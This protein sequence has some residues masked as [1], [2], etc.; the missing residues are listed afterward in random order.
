VGVTR[1]LG[2]PAAVV[3]NRADLGDKRV[4]AFCLAEEIPVVPE[5]PYD[6]RLAL[7]S[8]RGEIFALEDAGFAGLMH[9]LMKSV[10]LILENRSAAGGRAA[11]ALAP[12]APAALAAASPASAAAAAS[13]GPE[14]GRGSDQPIQL[15]VLSGK[16]GAGK[17]TITAAFASLA[18][19]VVL[20]DCDVDAANLYLVLD[21]VEVERGTFVSGRTAYID[22]QHCSGC[23]ACAEKCRFGAI[24]PVPSSVAPTQSPP[25]L[26]RVDPLVCEGCALCSYA[27]TCRAVE[28]QE[29]ERGEWFVSETRCGPLVH[30]RL[31]IGG[32]NSGKLVTQVREKALSLAEARNAS[33]LLID[34]PP[35]IGCPAIASVAGADFVLLVTEPTVSGSHDLFRAVDLVEGFRI[36]LAVCVNKCD[37]NPELTTE[38]ER[39]CLERGIPV[40]G[41]LSYD[42]AATAAQTE[43]K[44]V[45]EKGGRLAQEIEAMWNHIVTH[46]SE[47]VQA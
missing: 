14:E 41:R 30:A 38:I 42:N 29:A 13:S 18:E 1:W 10:S 11:A 9:E 28:M 35:G 21:P 31:G 2:I 44:T 20:A 32:E 43:G 34:G 5:I 15:V 22:P 8:S 37:I 27:C 40:I 45:V 47:G 6:E 25:A 26:Y 23:G 17:T 39:A 4:Q 46:V 36:P 16:G 19:Q 12:G 3:V 24:A 7:A 33:L